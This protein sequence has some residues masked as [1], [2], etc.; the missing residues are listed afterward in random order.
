MFTKI[1][2]PKKTLDVWWVRFSRLKQAGLIA[3]EGTWGDIN[4]QPFRDFP[5]RQAVEQ[6][7]D[8]LLKENKISGPIHAVLT[9]TGPLPPLIGIDDPTHYNANVEAYRQ[10]APRIEEIKKSSL[11]QKRHSIK[12]KRGSLRP[13]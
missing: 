8:Y 3:L 13:S 9:G 5:H 10:S 4:L 2:T 7:A 11:K 1:W 12:K 6:S